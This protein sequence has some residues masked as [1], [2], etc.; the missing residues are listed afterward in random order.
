MAFPATRAELE[1]AGYRF[2]TVGRCRGIRCSGELAWYWTPKGR[3][4]PFNPDGSPHWATCV[5]AAQFRT[6]KQGR[7]A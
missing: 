7:R 3:R 2:D 4:L 1:S 6:P 5:D